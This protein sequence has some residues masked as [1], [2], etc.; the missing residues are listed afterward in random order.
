MLSQV[1]QFVS[2]MET[3]ARYDY[4]NDWKML[5]IFVGGYDLCYACEDVVRAMPGTFYM[6]NTKCEQI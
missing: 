1:Q 6:S 4:D 5:T 2:L 3:D